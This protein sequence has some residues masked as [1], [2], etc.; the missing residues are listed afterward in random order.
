MNMVRGQMAVLWSLLFIFMFG[1]AFVFSSLEPWSYRESVYFCFV[2]LSTVGFGDFLPST[3]ISK[4][5]SIFF[6][7]FGLG[8]CML[9]VAVL[10]GLV[11]ETHERVHSLVSSNVEETAV[12]FS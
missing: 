8:V 2:T 1:G 5:F 3:T 9:I 7:L 6:M 11:A 10:T 4:V 12:C